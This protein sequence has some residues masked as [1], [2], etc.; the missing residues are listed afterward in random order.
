MDFK[1]IEKQALHLSPEHR[2]KL[3][4]SLLISLDNLSQA[5]IEET[6]LDEAQ[7]RAAEIEHLEAVA[8]YEAKQPGL[9][10]SYLADFDNT[11]NQAC[12]FPSRFPVKR[13]P[14]FRSAPLKRFPFSIIYRESTNAI[15][16][17][18]VAHHRRRPGLL[19]NQG[20]RD[21]YT[22]MSSHKLGLIGSFMGKKSNQSP[23][24][25]FS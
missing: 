16:I 1:A 7:R 25:V 17:I 15:Q 23:R 24:I 8:Y 12:D 11:I 5:E 13:Q 2:A 10:N 18:C 6:W 19:D 22:A 14:D 4:K 3:A 9:G 21:E 20:L